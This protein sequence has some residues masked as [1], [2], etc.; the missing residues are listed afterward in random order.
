MDARAVE[1][2]P[3]TESSPAASLEE[4]LSTGY[5][6]RSVSLA[7][8]GGESIWSCGPRS[9][10]VG[11]GCRHQRGA[12]VGPPVE[13]LGLVLRALLAC[14]KLG[15]PKLYCVVGQKLAVDSLSSV[16]AREQAV[17]CG[18][19]HAAIV[20]AVAVATREVSVEL[21]MDESVQARP[22]YA[23]S[24]DRVSTDLGTSFDYLARAAALFEVVREVYGSWLKV[25]WTRFNERQVGAV[26]ELVGRL[27]GGSL[28]RSSCEV[29]FDTYRDLR[30][31]RE[32]LDAGSFMSIYGPAALPFDPL[33]LQACPY[34]SSEKTRGTRILLNRDELLT[35][36]WKVPEIT[37]LEKPFRLRMAKAIISLAEICI[38]AEELLPGMLPPSDLRPLWEEYLEAQ[39]RTVRAEQRHGPAGREFTE[40]STALNQLTVN[41]ASQMRRAVVLGL[42]VL[43]LQFSDC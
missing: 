30:F 37:S 40:A 39:K 22:E 2:I 15:I 38:L 35:L 28:P 6:I 20:N 26:Y 42:G 18:G 17:R 23:A 7:R 29:V 43:I 9:A 8:V 41:L 1:R 12:S 36:G 3:Q 25:G 10:T 11:L 13:T 5:F 32:D 21:L 16:T 4:L 14:R 33:V 27:T 31:A 24:L 34:V 19:Q